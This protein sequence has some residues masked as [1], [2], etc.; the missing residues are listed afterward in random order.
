M[1][2]NFGNL[3]YDYIGATGTYT[4]SDYIDLSSNNNYLYTSN[5][6]NILDTKINITSNI[7]SNNIINVDYKYNL[8]YPYNSNSLINIKVD[9][10]FNSNI[11]IHNPFNSGKIYFKTTSPTTTQPLYTKIDYDNKLYVYFPGS[12]LPPKPPEWWCVEEKLSSIFDANTAQDTELTGLA[13]AINEVWDAVGIQQGQISQLQ[14]FTLLDTANTRI[15]LAVNGFTLAQQILTGATAITIAISSFALGM[16]LYINNNYVSTNLLNQITSNSNYTNN[17]RSNLSNAIILDQYSNC[18]KISSNSSNLNILNGFT[19]SNILTTQYIKSINTNEIKL[20]NL[21]FSN[22]FI[23]SNVASNTSNTI[24]NNYS[25]LNALT[26]A[27][28][29]NSSN[30]LFNYSS[31][32]NLNSSNNL[33]NSNQ[34]LINNYS[35]TIIVNLPYTK[36]TYDTPNNVYIYDLDISKYVPYRLI[37]QSSTLFIKTRIFRITTFMSTDFNKLQFTNLN[38]LVGNAICYPETL[39]IYMSND[40]NTSG[41]HT[42]DDNVNNCLIYGKQNP[43]A[44]AGYWSGVDTNF[45]YIRFITGVGFDTTILIEPI[46]F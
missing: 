3:Y 19:N 8:V 40:K 22:I 46:L 27:E 39:L 37:Q 16:A 15:A 26:L 38:N 21:N 5:S 24:F 25:N 1:D 23:T 14:L 30:N 18:L 6:S 9:E 7:L 42:A 44:F 2:N 33:F 45:N 35:K 36:F 41:V 13:L 11:Y 32:I 12:L 34:F 20:N 10:Y 17:E 43:N 28:G 4:I 31:N 29:L